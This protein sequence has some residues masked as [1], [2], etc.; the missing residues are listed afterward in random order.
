MKKSGGLRSALIVVALVAAAACSGPALRYRYQPRL[1]APGAD[2]RAA[3][4]IASGFQAV[5]G[6]SVTLLENGERAFPSMLRAISEARSS[7]HM[8]NNIFREGE[9]GRRFVE[10]LAA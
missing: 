9:I 8:E 5:D 4:S 10:A 6:N 7:I 3:L 1:T 2:L